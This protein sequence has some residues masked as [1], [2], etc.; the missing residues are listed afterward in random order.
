MMNNINIHL[1]EMTNEN[2]KTRDIKEQ[3]SEYTFL[4]VIT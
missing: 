3:I 4:G 1:E 2:I